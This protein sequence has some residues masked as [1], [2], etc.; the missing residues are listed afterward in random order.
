MDLKLLVEK[1]DLQMYQNLKTAIEL[2]K[3]S[4]GVVLTQEQKVLSLQTVIAF[5][6]ENNFP[7][8]ERT[9]YLPPKCSPCDSSAEKE[10]PVKWH[11]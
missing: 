11:S 4:N 6:L 1:L 2:G 3:W 5:E 10:T 9:G 7:E 8:E